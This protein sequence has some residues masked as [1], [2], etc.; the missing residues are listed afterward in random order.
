MRKI[1][2]IASIL[3]LLGTPELSSQV[4]PAATLEITF[5]GLRNNKGI[6]A[7]GLYKDPR[8]WHKNPDL[9][10]NWSKENIKDSCLTVKYENLPFGTYAITMMDD[11]DANLKMDKFMGL[12]RE[13]FGFSR[14]PKVGITA[15]KFEE[16]SFVVDKPH[17]EITIKV[18][19][20]LKG[21]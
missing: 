9:E 10:P 1:L 18:I 21:T 15:P 17:H 16:C 2:L 3:T 14:N 20:K 6:V 4:S 19:Y 8:G 13:G 7:I 11:E 12:P 5:K